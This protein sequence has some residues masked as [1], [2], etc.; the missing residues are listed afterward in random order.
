MTDM[1]TAL[2]IHP[3]PQALSICRL[4]SLDGI[5][6][7]RELFFLAKTDEEISL[8]CPTS[9]VPDNVLVREDG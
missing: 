1:Q 6:L 9:D 4:T 3:L 2:P 7:N 5:D 8:V